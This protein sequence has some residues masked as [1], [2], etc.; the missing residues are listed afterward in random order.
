MREAPYLLDR[1]DVI[2]DL[3]ASDSMGLLTD[4]D[5]TISEIASSPSE[6][7]VS[8]V[9]RDSLSLLSRHLPLVAAVSGRPAAEA[10]ETIGV[11][12]MVY[13]GNHGLDRWEGGDVRLAAGAEGYPAVIADVLRELKQSL[14]IGGLLLENKGVTASIHYRR[15]RDHRS[16]RKAILAAV[17]GLAGAR[18]LKVTEGR[19]VV[20][21]RPPLEID[22]GSAVCS[23]I[24]ER[25]LESAVYLG[26][27]STDADV[28]RAFH[29][30]DV[31]FKGL[32]IGVVSAET[33]QV[34]VENADFVVRG[35][36]EAEQ[37]L[38]LLAEEVAGKPGS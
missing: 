28:F 20:E 19:M 7:K 10:R 22:K 6:A 2:Q 29:E 38:R 23:L 34:V 24:R 26:D 17:E 13:V 15:S 30:R 14:S 4:V 11:E 35:V 12:G 25:R 1:F 32:G 16:A 9:C 3:L 8:E 21:L 31:G 36:S 5:G 18:D 37:F 27:D 33:P